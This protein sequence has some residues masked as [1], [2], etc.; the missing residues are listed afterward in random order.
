MADVP[1]KQVALQKLS[2]AQKTLGRIRARSEKMIVDF[3]RV[4]G[5]IGVAYA[6]GRLRGHATVTGM[7]LRIPK[8]DLPAPLTL[9]VAVAVLSATPLVSPTT[10]LVLGAFGMGA[11]SADACL[12]GF[13]HQA[14]RSMGLA[15][16]SAPA[17][18]SGFPPSGG[19]PTGGLPTGGLPTSGL[20]TSGFDASPLPTTQ[21]PMP[22]AA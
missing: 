6:T 21:M 11:A 20:P 22:A 9:G 8:T 19:F 16:A 2:R 14:A 18:P 4:V 7:D 12:L 17:M 13:Q 3:G 15:A 5:T 10:G 1:N